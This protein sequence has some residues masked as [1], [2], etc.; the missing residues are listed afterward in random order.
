MNVEDVVENLT[1]VKEISRFYD[2]GNEY[3]KHIKKIKK[4]IK[5]IGKDR[6]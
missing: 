5:R 3:K 4:E 6:K 2:Y 1:R